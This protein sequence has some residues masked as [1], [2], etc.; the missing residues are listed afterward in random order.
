ML[1][2]EKHNKQ[3]HLVC[4]GRK[5][6][7]YNKLETFIEDNNLRNQV[8]FLGF[9]SLQQLYS[10]YRY[11][12]LVVIPTLYEAGSFPLFEA[13]SIGS[14]VICS[15]TTSLPETIGDRQ[16]T[17]DPNSI[18]EMEARI[19]EMLNDDEL[20]VKNIENS[21][22]QTKRFSWEFVIKNFEKAYS[23]AIENFKAKQ[24]Q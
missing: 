9:I 10:L 17:F 16:F 5:S 12:S 2:R 23:T 21:K 3:V 13:M 20:R 8:S 6:S 1:I 18:D 19:M 7:Y 14:P 15:R 22:L 24:K 4:S 11:T